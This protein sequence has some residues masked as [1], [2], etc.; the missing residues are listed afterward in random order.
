LGRLRS[1]NGN[2][3]R[4]ELRGNIAKQKGRISET[5]RKCTYEKGSS[6]RR[7]ENYQRGHEKLSMTPKA[8]GRGGEKGNSIKF[9]EER[10][11]GGGRITVVSFSLGVNKKEKQR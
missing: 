10:V 11:G 3:A 5:S 7:P 6:E 2:K 9:E 8:F 1:M 4:L